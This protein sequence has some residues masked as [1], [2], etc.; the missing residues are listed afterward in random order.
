VRVT[1]VWVLIRVMAWVSLPWTDATGVTVREVDVE[2]AVGVSFAGV[3][4]GFFRATEW[5]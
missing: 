5:R 1:E 4:V 3:V 2:L